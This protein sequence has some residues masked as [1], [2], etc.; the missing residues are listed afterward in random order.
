MSKTFE[1]NERDQSQ[2]TQA[3]VSWEKL[4][5]YGIILFIL[6][7]ISMNFFP[8]ISWLFP[9]SALIASFGF[10]AIS[11]N[12]S[13]EKYNIQ[14][15]LLPFSMLPALY[16]IVVPY[17]AFSITNSLNFLHILILYMPFT[18]YIF[19]FKIFGIRYQN[20]DNRAQFINSLF[21]YFLLITLL[22]LVQRIEFSQTKEFAIVSIGIYMLSTNYLY[23]QYRRPL[24]N[25]LSV[26]ACSVAFLEFWIV[27]NNL[28][29]S[30]EIIVIAGL[31]FFHFAAGLINAELNKK[32]TIAIILE[33]LIVV[34]ASSTVII[35]LESNKFFL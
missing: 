32:L 1:L 25:F 19:L 13:N 35:Y 8:D 34:V 7:S 21:C 18:I 30:K 20:I 33:Y 22:I 3:L 5:I 26:I 9:I 17:L 16:L 24:V 28:I 4:F 2:N 31:I 14:L 15:R 6:F 29:L 12:Q 27:I 10:T 23:N 11:S